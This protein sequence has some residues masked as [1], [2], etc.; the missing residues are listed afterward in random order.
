MVYSKHL[1]TVFCRIV[2]LK[3]TLSWFLFSFVTQTMPLK[4]VSV[5]SLVCFGFC[6]FHSCSIILPKIFLLCFVWFL[7]FRW[8]F[9]CFCSLFSNRW[10]FLHTFTTES[11]HELTDLGRIYLLNTNDAVHLYFIAHTGDHFEL[12][13]K[14]QKILFCFLFVCLKCFYEEIFFH[15]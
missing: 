3:H 2:W 14:P 7:Y 10:C 4:R 9:V 11:S 5:Q 15:K 12:W 1:S 13:K 8:C 6:Y